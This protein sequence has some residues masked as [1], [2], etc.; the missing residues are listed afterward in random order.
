MFVEVFMVPIPL[1]S[2]RRFWLLY[3]AA[4]LAFA[5]MLVYVTAFR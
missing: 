5:A 2:R 3:G 4:F 1:G